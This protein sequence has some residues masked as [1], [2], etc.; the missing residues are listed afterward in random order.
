M[1]VC[2]RACV[3]ACVCV[4][5]YSVHTVIIFLCITKT[6]TKLCAHLYFDVCSSAYR[7]SNYPIHSDYRKYFDIIAV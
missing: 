7:C 5:L 1:C 4:C 6:Y 3:L 2:V